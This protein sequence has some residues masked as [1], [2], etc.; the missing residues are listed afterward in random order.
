VKG[1]ECVSAPSDYWGIKSILDSA[2]PS[3]EE[4]QSALRRALDLARS[5]CAEAGAMRRAI[6]ERTGCR[7]ELVDQLPDGECPPPKP[8]YHDNVIRFARR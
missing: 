3:T 7:V 1:Q 8:E 5:N 2:S 6:E 4:W